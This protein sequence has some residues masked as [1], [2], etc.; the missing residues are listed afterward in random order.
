MKGSIMVQKIVPI[1]LIVVVVAVAVVAWCYNW[2]AYGESLQM[3]RKTGNAAGID[4]TVTPHLLRHTF[5]TH[6]L[7]GG[8]D[9]RVIQELL[10]H[11]SIASTQIYASITQRRAREIYLRAHP[12]SSKHP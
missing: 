1:L 9:L 8:A 10:G 11:S 7:N 12:R 3:T 4:K 5:A 6:M 2:C